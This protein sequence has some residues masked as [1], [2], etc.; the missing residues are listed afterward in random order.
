MK[1]WFTVPYHCIRNITCPEDTQ[2]QRKVYVGQVLLES[3]LKLDTCEN[4]RDDLYGAKSTSRKVMTGVTRAIAETLDS[5]PEDFAV[6]NSG[7]TVVAHG[8]AVNDTNKMLRL[9]EPSVINGSQTK[10]V[11][12]RF[13]AK[14]KKN[15]IEPPQIHVK[16]EAIITQNLPLVAEIS[17][18]RNYQNDVLALSIAGR[19]GQLDELAN[20]VAESFP[21]FKLKKSET[22]LN[23]E[24]LPTEH[25]LQIIALLVPKKLWIRADGYKKAYAY[26]RK[27]T[28]LKEFCELHD[29][30]KKGDRARWLKDVPESKLKELYQ[31]YLDVAPQAYEIHQKWSSHQGFIGTRIQSIKREKG[32]ISHVPDGII[33]PVISCLSLFAKKTRRGW[34]IAQPT[35]CQD[36]NLIGMAASVYVSNHHKPPVMGRNESSYEMMQSCAAM[37]LPG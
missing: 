9:Y 11:A 10:G 4:V 19:R 33:F 26:S 24:Y 2:N 22:D 3:I 7:I 27:A 14:C 18:A 34:L 1:D 5:R 37:A 29:A 21:D 6:L 35:N 28:C 16:F 17:I 15:N 13:Y 8:V 25:L 36:K 12:E 23:D 20:S 31:F 30:V 32:K